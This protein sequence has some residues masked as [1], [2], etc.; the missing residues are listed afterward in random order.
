M[1]LHELFMGHRTLMGDPASVIA[2]VH[3]SDM[4]LEL[5]YSDKHA[6]LTAFKIDAGIEIIPVRRTADD[7][8]WPE[9]LGSLQRELT[10]TWSNV[11]KPDAKKL[12]ELV[13]VVYGSD[14]NQWRHG[15]FVREK[16]LM[17]IEP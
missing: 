10:I 15:F 4:I 12:S 13:F 11:M 9:A 2:P 8:V 5:K 1:S 16:D 6:D 3:Y 14:T 7:N 17:K